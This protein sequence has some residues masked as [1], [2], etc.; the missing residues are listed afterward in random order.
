MSGPHLQ[1]FTWLIY[2]PLSCRDVCEKN[3]FSIFTVH[4]LCGIAGVQCNQNSLI[5]NSMGTMTL[6]FP[7]PS[8]VTTVME[9]QVREEKQLASLFS[10]RLILSTMVSLVAEIKIHGYLAEQPSFPNP[11]KQITPI[12]IVLPQIQGWDNHIPKL[13]RFSRMTA[14]WV[15]VDSG[16]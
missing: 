14:H 13:S 11:V 12:V 15:E 1:G 5:Q 8:Y 2:H 16:I 4:I 7:F 9:R 6:L 3:N 10:S